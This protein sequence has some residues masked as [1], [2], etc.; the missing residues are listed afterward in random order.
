[1]HLVSLSDWPRDRIRQVLRLAGSVKK[2]PQNFPSRLSRRTLLLIFQK[3]SLR[4]RV[5]F[6]AGM[7]RL[8][9]QAIY[10][11]LDQVPWGTGKETPGDTARSASRYVDAIAARLF[12]QSDLEELAEGS[13]VPVINALTDLEHPCQALADVMT[14]EEKRGPLEGLRLAYVGDG[15]SNVAHSLL[16]A[17][18]KT[19]IHVTIGCPRGAAYGPEPAILDRAR[20]AAAGGGSEIRVVHDAREA[21]AEAD[22]VYTDSWMSYHI[23]PED[24]A[25]RDRVFR[26]FQVTDA[27]LEGSTQDPLFMHCLP[28]EREREVTSEVLDG[29][30]SVVFDQ[31]ENRIHVAMALLIMLIDPQAQG[32]GRAY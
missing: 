12:R 32:A 18:A 6:E 21:V 25:A 19:G 14:L 23:P 26:P 3:P 5:S 7:A 15:R 11:G 4:T 29:R 24:R 1:M 8:G 9:G 30:R 17:C 20:K 27:L 22:A 16:D 13:S 31:A 10:C 2:H 28:A